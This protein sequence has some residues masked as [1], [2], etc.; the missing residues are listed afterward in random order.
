MIKGNDI[1]DIPGYVSVK[2]AAQILDVSV[3]RMYEYVRE[4][5]LPLHKA[6]KTYMIPIESLKDFKPQ[7][8]GR[9]RVRPPEW[10]VYRGGGNV[11]ATDIRAHV[12]SGQQESLI[13]KLKI[14][15]EENRHTF[16]GTIARYVLKDGS[17]KDGSSGAAIS[18]WLIWKD[19]EMP[20]EAIRDRDLA[21]FKAELADM[22][23]WETAQVSLKEG[24]IYT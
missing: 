6:G 13:E 5:R 17:L 4:R 19:T 2:E 12:R 3:S 20:D 9:M 23:D 21:D 18:I 11:L 24:L 22:L 14:I 15:Q 10:R 1:P 16:P 8:T 7:P